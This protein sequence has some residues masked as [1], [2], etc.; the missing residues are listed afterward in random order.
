MQAKQTM[1]GGLKMKTYRRRAFQKTS[2]L[3]LADSREALGHLPAFFFFFIN[4]NLQFLPIESIIQKYIYIFFQPPRR[5]LL[6][7]KQNTF[8]SIVLRITLE[9]LTCTMVISRMDGTACLHHVRKYQNGWQTSVFVRC[10]WKYMYY[11][12]I[13]KIHIYVVIHT[14]YILCMC[15]ICMYA[16]MYTYI[17]IHTYK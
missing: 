1:V 11:G 17:Y 6:K 5:W 3:F 10:F 13:Y 16:Y 9:F 14:T 4:K 8:E 15:N 12:Y 7:R 2:Y